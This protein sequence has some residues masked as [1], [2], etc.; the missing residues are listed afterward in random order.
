MD[1]LTLK[2]SLNFVN[3]T[4]VGHMKRII[5]LIGFITSGIFSAFS[6]SGS[7]NDNKILNEKPVIL[8]SEK[9]YD[10]GVL[11]TGDEAVHYFVFTNKGKSPLV[12]SN[13]RSSC[14]CAVSK[15]PKMPLA[16][17]AKDS[18]RVEYNTD[19]RG[20]FNKTITVQSN[21]VGGEVVLRIRG[22]VVKAK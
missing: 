1:Y 11:K 15:W 4:T 8:F 5:V 16:A 2:F 6:Q 18:L 12:I 14:G 22:E 3:F 20:T 13:V 17:D 9:E 10:F 19:I 7:N 21:A